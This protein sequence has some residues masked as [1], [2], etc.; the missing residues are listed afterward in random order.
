MGGFQSPYYSGTS[1]AQFPEGG[2][3]L[4]LPLYDQVTR[5]VH[6]R[7]SDV[8]KRAILGLYASCARSPDALVLLPVTV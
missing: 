6:H 7:P 4:W 8:S 5:L 3:V 2:I 1:L